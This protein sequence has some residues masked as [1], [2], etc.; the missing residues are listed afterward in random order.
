VLIVS[1]FISLQPIS[2][3]PAYAQATN[4][5]IDFT[6]ISGMTTTSPVP[7]PSTSG[8]TAGVADSGGLNF[9]LGFLRSLGLQ[10]ESGEIDTLDLAQFIL[11]THQSYNLENLMHYFGVPHT[12][13]HRALADAKATVK[14]LQGL[15][16][17][18]AGFQADLKQE[19]IELSE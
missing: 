15:L 2:E 9:D 14:V 4:P 7:S 6:M 17:S 19:I 1:G 5:C 12:E 10:F 11:P 3:P 16:A 13:A 18:F 8:R